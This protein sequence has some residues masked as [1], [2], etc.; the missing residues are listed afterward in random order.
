MQTIKQTRILT[1]LL[2]TID[3]QIL[4]QLKREQKK[5]SI[6]SILKLR[7][8]SRK[9]EKQKD[10][11]V[12]RKLR[13]LRFSSRKTTLLQDTLLLLLKDFKQLLSLDTCTKILTKTRSRA[14]TAK[15]ARTIL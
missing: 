13:I 9:L 1:I 10:N 15:Q 12:F 11:R 6:L 7:E 2:F 8:Q 5:N 14:L 4:Q 3:K